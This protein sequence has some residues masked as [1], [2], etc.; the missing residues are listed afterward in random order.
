LNPQ[1]VKKLCSYTLQ[2]KIGSHTIKECTFYDHFTKL[3]KR[4]NILGHE[5]CPHHKKDARLVWW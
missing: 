3:C 4:F 5:F 1:K 2:E